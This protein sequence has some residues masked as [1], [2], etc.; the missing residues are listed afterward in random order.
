MR[1]TTLDLEFLDTTG[2]IAAFLVEGPSGAILVES[3]PLSTR[4]TLVAKLKEAGLA[5]EDLAGVFV[6]HIHLDHAGAAG[7]LAERGA[8]VHVHPKGARHL[9]DPT[10]LVESSREV[11]GEDFERLWAGMDAAPEDRVVVVEDGE[12][13]TAGGIEVRAL[14]TPGHAFHHHAWIVG[15]TVF[16][17]DAA[18]AAVD[19]S[20]FISVTSA[21]PQFHLD[22]T[23]ESIDKLREIAPE[24]L[25]LTHFGAVGDP[26]DHLSSYREAVEM[27][28]LFVKQ[29]MEEGMDAEALRI[30]YQAFQMEQAFRFEAPRESWDALRKINGPEMCA[31]GI[32][33]YWG[34][35]EKL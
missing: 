31:D 32:R 14:A 12:T 23:L 4:D 18:G 15:D 35:V 19:D 10:R 34:T 3:G 16:A 30:A 22:Y 8:P 6:T 11:Y 21:P 1:V 24:T 27:N 17:G 7:W 13:V 2:A 25:Y 5:P 33:L 28:A 9:I 29:R 26:A 20:G